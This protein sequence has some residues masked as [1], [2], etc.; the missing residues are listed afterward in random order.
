MNGESRRPVIL[1]AKITSSGGTSGTS[2]NCAGEQKSNYLL[3]TTQVFD[4]P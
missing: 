4:L 1:K 2:N 3:R